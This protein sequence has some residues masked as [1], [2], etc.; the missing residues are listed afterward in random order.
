MNIMS[1]LQ[2]IWSGT[3]PVIA[4]EISR[5]RRS[6]EDILRA[7][8][9]TLAER[10]DDNLFV[11]YNP[12]SGVIGLHGKPDR[13]GFFITAYANHTYS[14]AEVVAQNDGQ[15]DIQEVLSGVNIGKY[16]DFE[17]AIRGKLK[18]LVPS[19]NTFSRPVREI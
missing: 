18:E 6:P 11:N 9:T 19:Q 13:A 17:K 7:D 4:P 8:L 10:I 5:P 12:M 15:N 16:E 14:V 1:K 2:N 3:T